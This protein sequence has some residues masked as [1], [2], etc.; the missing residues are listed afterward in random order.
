MTRA[1]AIN[2]ATNNPTETAAIMKKNATKKGLPA[3]YFEN[4]D[5]TFPYWFL[6]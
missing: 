3:K 1:K 6:H 2:G 4:T 5:W